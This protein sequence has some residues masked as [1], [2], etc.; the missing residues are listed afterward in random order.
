[1]KGQISFDTVMKDD[2]D[3]PQFDGCYRI[4]PDDWKIFFCDAILER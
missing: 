4:P 2:Q 1:M 3:S